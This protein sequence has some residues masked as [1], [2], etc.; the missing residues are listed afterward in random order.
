MSK[1]VNPI[2]CRN[3]AAGLFLA[4]ASVANAGSAQQQHLRR[5]IE[6]PHPAT[7]ASLPRTDPREWTDKVAQEKWTTLAPRSA[8]KNGMKPPIRTTHYVV[9]TDSSCGE[10]FGKKMEENYRRVVDTLEFGEQVHEPRM[11]IFLFRTQD[12]YYGFAMRAAGISE[13]EAKATGGIAVGEWYATWYE[14]P[15]DSAHRSGAA[16][17]L[18][19]HR[20]RLDGDRSWFSDGI[21]EYIAT[22]RNDRN[23]VAQK[24]AHD[25]APLLSEV[26][27]MRNAALCAARNDAPGLEPRELQIESALFIEFLRE[28]SFGKAGAKRFIREFASSSTKDLAAVDRTLRF[29]YGEGLASIEKRFREYCKKR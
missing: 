14:S 22:K 23:A 10:S 26:M 6:P 17:Q 8:I 24:I 29:V 21:A 1:R 7:T 12:E 11:P 5:R 16:R 4:I 2:P 25:K 28:S 13:S 9:L 15:C 3:L 27:S 19:A 20:M 18:L